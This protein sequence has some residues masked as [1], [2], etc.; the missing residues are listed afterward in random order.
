MDLDR[1]QTPVRR[2]FFRSVRWLKET[3]TFQYRKL[4]QMFE[5]IIF[6]SFEL[7]WNTETP[8]H[9]DERSEIVP[10]CREFN[11]AQYCQLLDEVKLTNRRKGPL[12]IAALTQ[13]KLDIIIGN[14]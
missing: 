3:A 11:V 4:L 7:I 13:E 2:I 5:Y 6:R 12:H 14:H 1:P 9:L 8:R 10:F